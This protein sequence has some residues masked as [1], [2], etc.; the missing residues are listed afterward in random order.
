MESG[1]EKD[2]VLT[3]SLSRKIADT[4]FTSPTGVR[5]WSMALKGVVETSDNMAIISMDRKNVS[6][7]YS[8][9]SSVETS[10]LNLAYEIQTL[11][12][13]NGFKVKIG[14]GYPA[15]APNPDSKFTKEVSQAYRKITGKEP[16]ITAIHAGLECGTIND[17]IPGM[18]SLSIGPNLFDVH[19]VNEHVEVASAERIASFVKEMLKEIK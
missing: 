1:E 16:V 11:L 5:S 2:M 14:G 4:I 7:V 8:I 19:S 10:K 12:E 9:R 6:I 15:W 3:E 13:G 18:D 17:R